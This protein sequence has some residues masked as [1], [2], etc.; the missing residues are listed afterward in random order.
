MTK[1]DRTMEQNT[2]EGNILDVKGVSQMFRISKNEVHRLV[3]TGQLPVLRFGK[4]GRTLRF[5]KDDILK[6]RERREP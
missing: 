2:T 4:R 6:L 1:A 5:V 3:H